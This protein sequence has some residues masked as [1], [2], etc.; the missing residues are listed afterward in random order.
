MSF[1]RLIGGVALEIV[2][3]AL[4]KAA[5]P[6]KPSSEPSTSSQQ[7]NTIWWLREERAKID[8]YFAANASKHLGECKED[9]LALMQIV[10]TKAYEEGG[11]E[12]LEG[13]KSN[14]PGVSW[15]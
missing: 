11:E 8:A 12:M 15:S 13:I 1:A 10:V 14:N 9:L 4:T 3:T 2:K 6:S 5:A 7:P